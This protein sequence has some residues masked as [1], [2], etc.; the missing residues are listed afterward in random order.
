MRKKSIPY[1]ANVV[2]EESH[3]CFPKTVFGT[4]NSPKLEY[5]LRAEVSKITNKHNKKT[6]FH[7]LDVSYA[8]TCIF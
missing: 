7:K 3:V 1:L 5:E 4:G 2:L 6:L 8:P